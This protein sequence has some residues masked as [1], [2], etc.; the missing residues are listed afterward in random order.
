MSRGFWTTFY[1]FPI[2]CWN[3]YHPY[4]YE[5]YSRSLNGIKVKSRYPGIQG[6]PEKTELRI[7]DPCPID[8]THMARWGIFLED[9]LAKDHPIRLSSSHSMPYFLHQ[10]RG[11]IW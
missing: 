5:L 6:G 9:K 1:G 7:S 11:S 4:L 10:S 3:S 8:T 2:H